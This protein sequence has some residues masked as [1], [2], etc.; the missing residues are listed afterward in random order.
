M[1]I[2]NINNT[3]NKSK[4]YPGP[5]CIFCGK[6]IREDVMVTID[7]DGNIY[8]CCHNCYNLAELFV[9]GDK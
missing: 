4:K 9:K 7:R 6:P 5:K 8:N 2:N 3:R 1:K